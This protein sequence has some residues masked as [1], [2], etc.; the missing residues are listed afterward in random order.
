MHGVFYTDGSS[1]PNPGYSG[2]GIHGYLYCFTE[3][4]LFQKS[5]IKSKLFFTPEGYSLTKPEKAI[6]IISVVECSC[7]FDGMTQTNNSA[8]LKA[9][10]WALDNYLPMEELESITIITDS[11]Y[12]VNCFNNNLIKWSETGW[13][14]TDGQ[15]LANKKEWYEIWDITTKYMAFGKKVILKWIKGHNEKEGEEYYGNETAD[16]YAAIGSTSSR[17][18][19]DHLTI[20]KEFVTEI[21]HKVFTLKEYK[22]SFDYKDLLFNFKHLYF[23]TDNTDD[24]LYCFLFSPPDPIVNLG[25]KTLESVFAINLGYVPEVINNLKAYHRAI[26]RDF[27]TP[28]AL[29]ISTLRNSNKLRLFNML[30]VEYLL[31]VDYKENKTCLVNEAMPIMVDIQD[32]YPLIN[33]IN[34]IYDS[35]S[36]IESIEQPSDDY[37]Y[38]ITT[39]D[40]TNEL[41]IEGKV[42]ISNQVKNLDITNLLPEAGIKRSLMTSIN[43]N[44]GNDLLSYLAMKQIESKIKSVKVKLGANKQT[45]GITC[46][47]IYELEDRS[48]L[49]TNTT[50]KFLFRS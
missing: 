7:A 10:K 6:E 30:P 42:V 44:I 36:K 3:K 29:N 49:V 41:F 22:L 15:P 9:T 50:N 39:I 4:K 16:L 17:Y 19:Q 35:M 28:A 43:L 33:N 48:L 24:R 38:Y 20:D 13:V 25:M 27:F 2:G 45:N 46:L 18:Q 37:D 23:S 14:R 31:T 26:P 1:K 21:M 32:K 5:P 12:V 8:E 34:A 11:S 40:I 47:V